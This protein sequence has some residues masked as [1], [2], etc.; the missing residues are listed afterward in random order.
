MTA[1]HIFAA[2]GITVVLC[3]IA[4]VIAWVCTINWRNVVLAAPNYLFQAALTEV[5]NIGFACVIIVGGIFV[6]AVLGIARHIGMS[7]GDAD[8]LVEIV[9]ILICGG[10]ALLLLASMSDFFIHVFTGNH[11]GDAG[12]QTVYQQRVHDTGKL[13][14]ARQIDRALRDEGPLNG[15]PIFDE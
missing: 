14:D 10:G 2:F 15:E 13:A 12:L 8:P 9:P 11:M 4:T 5:G 7:L 1:E 6:G 3:A